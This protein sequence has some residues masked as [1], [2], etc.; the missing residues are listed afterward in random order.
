MDYYGGALILVGV[1]AL[2]CLFVKLSSNEEKAIPQFAR[3]PLLQ[4]WSDWR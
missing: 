3:L 1:G 4:F 2:N